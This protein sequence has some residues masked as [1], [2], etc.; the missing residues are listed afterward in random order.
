MPKKMAAMTQT[1]SSVL[2]YTTNAAHPHPS[3]PHTALPAGS[4]D[5]H[6]HVF[7]PY[8]EFALAEPRSYTPPPAPFSRM[9]QL[10][11]LLGVARAVLVQPA[12]HGQD[13]SAMLAAIEASGHQYRGVALV[14]SQTPEAE[15]ARLHQGGVRGARL[16]FVAHL[17]GAPSLEEFRALALKLQA[18]QWH[19]CMHVDGAALR[20]WLPELKTLPVP[21][22]IDH[23][24]RLNSL[25]PLGLAQPDMQTLLEA[26]QLPNAWLKISAADRTAQGQAPYASSLPYMQELIATRPERLLWGTDWPHP[27]V[28]GEVPNDG[29]LVDLLFQACPDASVRQQILVH[30]PLQLYAD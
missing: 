19:L 7:G 18:Q 15:M 24:A 26:L 16:N 29:E 12:C 27:N 28:T 17:G 13:H 11:Q 1:S 23:M 22:I 25:H 30:N 5:C 10:H 2:R 3:Q 21:F 14:N 9:Q 4:W 20:Q 6:C 8:A